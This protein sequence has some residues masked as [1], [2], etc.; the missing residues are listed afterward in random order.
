MR[1]SG[2]L[3][4]QLSVCLVVVLPVTLPLGDAIIIKGAWYSFGH[5][6]NTSSPFL[7]TFGK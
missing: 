6:C 7:R 1:I 5:I 4:F 3:L 2:F